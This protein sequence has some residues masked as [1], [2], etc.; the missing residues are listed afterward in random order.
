MIKKLQALGLM[1]KK[2][3]T[4]A[5]LAVSASTSKVIKTNTTTYD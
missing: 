1:H 4:A 5:I 3:L 2:A